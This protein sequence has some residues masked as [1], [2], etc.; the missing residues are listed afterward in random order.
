MSDMYLYLRV[1]IHINIMKTLSDGLLNVY[2]IRVKS[3]ALKKTLL[4]KI[5][6]RSF[7]HFDLYTNN[8]GDYIFSY[9]CSIPNA[10]DWI[11]IGNQQLDVHIKQSSSMKKKN[12]LYIKYP[13]DHNQTYITKI[14]TINKI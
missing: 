12:D 8:D 9:K 4:N 3:Y 1:K 10:N 11:K 14:I 5:N 6:G 2:M 13:S 7:V